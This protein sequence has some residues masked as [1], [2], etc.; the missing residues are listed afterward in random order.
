[1]MCVESVSFVLVCAFLVEV[2]TCLHPP[3]AGRWLCKRLYSRMYPWVAV[4]LLVV[5]WPLVAVR[6]FAHGCVCVRQCG[7]ARFEIPS[8]L[9]SEA[10]P[11]A[12]QAYLK[13]LVCLLQICIIIGV[14]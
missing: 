5:V 14:H 12:L 10:L 13:R 11:Q 3:P 8:D 7:I 9:L 4:Q 1:M 2:A 6:L